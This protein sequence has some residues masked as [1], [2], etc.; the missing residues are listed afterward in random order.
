MYTY[1]YTCMCIAL[2]PLSESLYKVAIKTPNS[3]LQNQ[4]NLNMHW[5]LHP[6]LKSCLGYGQPAVLGFTAEGSPEQL[7]LEP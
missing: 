5:A 2:Y 1:N 6:R 7:T 3:L 4:T